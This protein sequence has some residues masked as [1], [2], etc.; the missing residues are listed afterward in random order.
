ME[1]KL[2]KRTMAIL[3]TFAKINLNVLIEE[4]KVIKTINKG[5][6]LICHA[7]VEENFPIEFGVWDLGELLAAIS[8]FPDPIFNF[9]DSEEGVCLDI[10]DGKNT[11]IQYYPCDRNYLSKPEN[12][13]PP[14]ETLIEFQLTST[15]INNLTKAAASMSLEDLVIEIVSDNKVKVFVSNV[16]TKSKNRTEPVYSIDIDADIKDGEI[17]KQ[18]YIDVNELKMYNCDYT[19]AVKKNCVEII[20]EE[21]KIQYWIS[22][23]IK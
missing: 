10:S 7:Q 15:E 2:S 16:R 19:F 14:M 9:I 6:N 13:I 18:I 12:E 23:T 11:S 20:G 4:G 8:F 17:G 22:I 1:I 21:G 5:K 3:N